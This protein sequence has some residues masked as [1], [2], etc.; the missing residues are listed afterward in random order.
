MLTDILPIWLRGTYFMADDGAGG[1]GGGTGDPPK[2]ETKPDPKP[3][4][5]PAPKMLTQEEVNAI[6]ARE[7]DQGARAAEQRISEE[8]G[9]PLDEAKSILAAH[10]QA[11]QE[12]KSQEERLAE[13]QAELDKRDEDLKAQSHKLSVAQHLIL[14]GV[15]DTTKQNRIVAILEAEGKIPQGV[16][17]DDIS[18]AVTKLKEEEPHLFGP[19][20]TP[21]PPSGGPRGNPPKPN[22]KDDAMSRG[23]ERAR[24]SGAARPSSYAF[25]EKRK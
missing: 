12:K 1:G 4:A 2:P 25:L 22:L 20:S 10:R 13:R 8:L 9:V 7:K 5:P 3:P 16:K 19:G 14:A 11:E 23:A 17:P 21:S 6:A 24:Q 18:A 15:T